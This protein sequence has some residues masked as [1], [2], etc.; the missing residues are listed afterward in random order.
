[1]TLTT[2][3]PSL[4]PANLLDLRA[5]VYVFA[6]GLSVH[7]TDHL[8]RGLGTDNHHAAWPAHIQVILAGGTVLISLFAVALVRSGHPWAPIGAA[9]IGFGAAGTFLFLHMSPGWT[10]WIDTFFAPDSGAQVTGYSWVTATLGI[11]SCVLLGVAGVLAA[12]RGTYRAT[13]SGH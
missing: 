7:G 1:M 10:W 9:V 5:A 3:A 12:R 6:V 2:R 13:A 8:I 4:R 11:S